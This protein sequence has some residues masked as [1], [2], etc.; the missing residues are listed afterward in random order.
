MLLITI[1]LIN[2]FQASFLKAASFY[3][4][5]MTLAALGAHQFMFVAFKFFVESQI[6]YIAVLTIARSTSIGFFSSLSYQESLLCLMYLQWPSKL[7]QCQTTHPLLV[8]LQ[9]V[10]FY[11]PWDNKALDRTVRCHLDLL[12][13]VLSFSAGF[14]QHD[15]TSNLR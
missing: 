1:A 6:S 9:V 13:R 12:K 2:T 15:S 11:E 7:V 8:N 4:S 3:S 5:Y 14:L 10:D